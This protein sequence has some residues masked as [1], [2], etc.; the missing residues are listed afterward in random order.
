[1]LRAMSPTDGTELGFHHRLFA[2]VAEEMGGTLLRTAF[3]PN[4]KERRDFSC[5]VFDAA[6]ALVA[7]AAHIPVHL[8][9]LPISMA[10]VLERHGGEAREGDVFIL[11]DPFAGGTHLPDITL[12][13]P[14]FHQGAVAAWLA[15]RAHHADVGGMT[16]GSLP[17]STG[18]HQEGLRLPPL[19]LTPEVEAILLANTRTPNERRGDLRAQRAAHVV[20]TRRMLEILDA[21]G[22]GAIAAVFDGLL[23][24]GERLMASLIERIPDGEYEAED[25][26]D[27]D[28]IGAEPLPIRARLRIEAGRAE[29]DFAGTAPACAGS[30]NA[31]EAITRSAVYY[32]FFCLLSTPSELTAGMDDPPRNAGCLRRVEVRAPAGSIVNARPPSAVAAGNVETSQ[33]IVDVVF[34]A[35]AEALPGVIPAASQGTMNNLCAGGVDPRRGEPFAYYETMGGGMGARPGAE[36]LSGVQVHM[37]NTLNTPVEALEYALPFR[38]TRYEIAR[39]TGGEGRWRG[40]DGLVREYEFDAATEVTLI[41]ERRRLAPPGRAG[42]KEGERGR[43]TLNGEDVGG[44]ATL[45]LRP[46][47]RLGMVTPGGGGHGPV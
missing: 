47:D 25:A 3:S 8:G 24:Y 9:A 20:G 5:A 15:T 31:V 32:C 1:M 17:L 36:G 7:Q 33:R 45:R 21:H 13:S 43:N 19:P 2:S 44:K 42:G 11:N 30:L 26:L 14:V 12:V 18:I 37:T 23:A 41:T 4:I 34:A 27:G 29:V 40:G 6:G 22:A 39:G 16:P 10:A 28:G 38:V 46:G 35:L